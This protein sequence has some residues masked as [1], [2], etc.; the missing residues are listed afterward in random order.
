MQLLT[1]LVGALFAIV[2]N[3]PTSAQVAYVRVQNT[4]GGYDEGRGF[5]FAALN[6]C[7]LV[8][9]A[10]LVSQRNESDKTSIV[11]KI[12]N[13][14][15]QAVP[16]ASGKWIEL[17][18]PDLAVLQ[19]S[20]CPAIN[21][22]PPL[23]LPSP[24]LVI[25]RKSGG[26]LDFIKVE[27]TEQYKDLMVVHATQSCLFEKSISGSLVMLANKIAGL[28]ISVG[29]NCSYVN[30]LPIQMVDDFL[31]RNQSFHLPL[32]PYSQEL[33]SAAYAADEKRFYQ[34][35]KVVG[36]PNTSDA[37]GDVLLQGVATT[38]NN[39]DIFVERSGLKSADGG[40]S[41]SACEAWIDARVRMAETLLKEGARPDGRQEASWTPLMSAVT[42]DAQCDNTRMVDTLLK[43]KAD[44]NHLYVSN[45]SGTASVHNALM[46]AVQDGRPPTVRALL[47][48]GADANAKVDAWDSSGLT[49]I[50]AL[51]TDNNPDRNGTLLDFSDPGL[52]ESCWDTDNAKVA[53][54]RLL[55]PYTRLS[56]TLHPSDYQNKEFEGLTVEGVLK[57]RLGGGCTLS[58]C[59]GS[60]R[61]S[62]GRCLER[63]LGALRAY[64]N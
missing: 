8:T 51:A 41:A 14:N 34:L 12:E 52:D 54:F 24:D 44:P 26:G 6:K 50:F 36:D 19:L 59:D 33:M 49:P 29:G 23:G 60:E 39:F 56:T 32:N 27:Q 64:K 62:R 61:D 2:L 1:V 63:M 4:G 7:W 57:K 40:S 5:V 48:S 15:F 38:H 45:I 53:K 17:E 21:Q 30:V 10:H 35:L 31:L 3:T 58:T 42:A 11:V 16:P 47:L 20:E 9:A 18:K 13:Q 22:E 37:S 55:V 46:I 25:F 43:S 28:A